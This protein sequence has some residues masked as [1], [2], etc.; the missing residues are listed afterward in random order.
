MG[1]VI[2]IIVV[3]YIILFIVG[4][5]S[6]I[7]TS[8]GLYKIAKREEEKTYAFAWVPYLNQYLLGKLAFKSRVQ[9]II[10]LILNIIVLVMSI[11]VLFI[12]IDNIHIMYIAIASFIM[13][14]IT[15]VYTFIA[16]YKIYSKYSRSTVLMTILD[17]ISF[18]ILGPI[19]I[20]AIRN[21][22]V[23]INN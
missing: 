2:F 15:C 18:G 4:F 21:N 8:F 12:S 1:T 9:A 20:F 5:I 19:F 3:S 7:F 10:M 22:E 16:H 17:I 13:S 6:Y 14:L 11:S 23:K